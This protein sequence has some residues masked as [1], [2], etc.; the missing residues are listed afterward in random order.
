MTKKPTYEELEQRVKAL[1]QES[2]RR[3]RV[4]EVLR[5]SE[6]KYRTL[7]ENAVEAIIVAQDGMIKFANTQGEEL[8]G[9]SKEELV[10]E[11]LTHFIHEEDRGLV[12]DRHERRLKGEDLPQIY[13]FRIIDKQGHIKWVELK[14]VLFAWEG[15]PATLCFMT[16]ITE[17]RIAKKELEESEARYQELFDDAP[18]GYHEIDVE[19]RITRINRTELDML[20]SMPFP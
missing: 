5:E 10:Q 2:I 3:K 9:R 8:Y 18:V 13:P 7:I 12:R 16:D 11:P 4:E 6:E 14:V 20:G 15:N 17:R 1:E 19:G